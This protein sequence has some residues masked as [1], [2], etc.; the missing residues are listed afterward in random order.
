MVD[1][2]MSSSAM[3]TPI[4]ATNS[5]GADVPN[6]IKVAPAISAGNFNAIHTMMDLL[7][8]TKQT[9]IKINNLLLPIYS[10][11]VKKY[12]SQIKPNERQT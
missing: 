10:I 11:D 6:A 12:K 2:P 5:S 1:V 8:N 7:D 3:K 9:I 4:N